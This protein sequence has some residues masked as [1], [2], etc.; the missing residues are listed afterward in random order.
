MVQ[1]P[2]EFAVVLP[3]CVE[4][5]NSRT[6]LPAAAV[7]VKVGVV[8]LVRLSVVDDPESDAAIKS[9]V[10]GAATGALM[11]IERAAD[12][13]L[14]LPAVSVAVTVMMC[15][16]CARGEL[17]TVQLPLEFAVAVPI[18]VVPAYTFTAL[19]ASAVPVKVGVVLVVML[20]V[21]D[22]PVS[23]AA[24]KSGV[25][26]AAT[27]VSILIERA[28]DVGL[29]VLPDVAVAVMFCVPCA[30]TE[31]VTVQLPLEF[32]VAVPI[33]VVPAY[34]VT[35]LAT[36][37]VPVKVGVVSLVMLSLADNPVSDAAV[38]SGVEGAPDVGVELSPGR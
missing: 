28:P 20:S 21:F 35:V 16:P 13:G 12:A 3:I 38:R 4:P 22:A 34:T 14:V 18:W 30:R 23:E 7:P 36:S 27:E 10:D 1:L 5:S 8:S 2:L 31:L 25:D 29:V 6:V 17:V 32:A 24:V 33:W 15:V 11:V 9:G 26:G 19:P 37:A